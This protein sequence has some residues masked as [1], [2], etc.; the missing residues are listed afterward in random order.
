MFKSIHLI[1]FRI[2]CWHSPFSFE[3]TFIRVAALLLSQ[4]WFW[5]ASSYYLSF[6]FGCNAYVVFRCDNRIWM[7]V[8]NPYTITNST[9]THAYKHELKAIGE[10]QMEN[11]WL[12]SVLP[13]APTKDTFRTKQK[14]REEFSI[15]NTTWMSSIDDCDSPLSLCL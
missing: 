4:Q 11:R 8:N 5:F 9:R 12:G 15:C 13:P 7:W 2:C 1:F 10:C 3:F 14:H 6:C